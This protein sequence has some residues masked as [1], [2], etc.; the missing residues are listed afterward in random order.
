MLWNIII[1]WHIIIHAIN[2]IL[3]Q[4]RN[5]CIKGYFKPWRK[6]LIQTKRPY[7][8]S[9][10]YRGPE[11]ISSDTSMT[12]G[13]GTTV[14]FI[15]QARKRRLREGEYLVQ[16]HR[17]PKDMPGAV[18]QSYSTPES[19]GRTWDRMWIGS[20]QVTELYVERVSYRLIVS[21]R[22]TRGS[23]GLSCDRGLEG[24]IKVK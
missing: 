17:L 15:L 21:P 19:H 20:K 23:L 9:A 10:V 3:M 8:R 24:V 12:T 13:V 2:T 14:T 7:S 22:S 1:L 16:S 11:H 6:F 5:K 4:Y 18:T